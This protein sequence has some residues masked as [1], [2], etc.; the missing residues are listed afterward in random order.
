MAEKLKVSFKKLSLTNNYVFI[1][2]F[3]YTP[4]QL[5][6]NVLSVCVIIKYDVSFALEILV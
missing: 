1:H 3:M 5:L 6:N 4:P 2:Y